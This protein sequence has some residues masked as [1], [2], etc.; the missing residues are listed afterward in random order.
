MHLN[1]DLG[2]HRVPDFPQATIYAGAL[3]DADFSPS[4]MRW[5]LEIH[6]RHPTLPYGAFFEDML[7]GDRYHA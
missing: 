4:P 1:F 6:V 2:G 3:A 5:T 7:P